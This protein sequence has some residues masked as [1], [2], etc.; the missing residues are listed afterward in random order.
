MILLV[1]V[2]FMVGSFV[3]W[4]CLFECTAADPVAA[5]TTCHQTTP[6]GP[7]VTTGDDCTGERVQVSPFVKT[8]GFTVAVAAAS[9]GTVA[10][11]LTLRFVDR[12]S[13]VAPRVGPPDGWAV[14]PLRI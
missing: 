5:K 4:P 8:D 13:V 9:T 7:K 14:I 1:L 10:L 12:P 2:A 11:R 3:N 6:D